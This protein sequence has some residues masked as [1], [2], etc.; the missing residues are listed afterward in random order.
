MILKL[1]W[2]CGLGTK[3][4]GASG[5]RQRPLGKVDPLTVILREA[6]L[7][8]KCSRQFV[9]LIEP[10][11]QRTGWKFA[12]KDAGARCSLL[13]SVVYING[14]LPHSFS[15]KLTCKLLRFVLESWLRYE[16]TNFRVVELT[17]FVWGIAGNNI[18]CIPLAAIFEL[19]YHSDHAKP[20]AR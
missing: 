19:F 5:K 2:L 9:A 16:V 18:N 3:R 7:L 6:S 4:T 8:I 10:R 13:K 12:A 20:T 1:W 17:S 15:L 14:L 11:Q